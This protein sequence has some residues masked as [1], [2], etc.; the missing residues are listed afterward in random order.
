MS[1]PH[2]MTPLSFCFCAPSLFLTGQVLLVV[3]QADHIAGW[4]QNPV[5]LTSE[6]WVPTKLW[7]HLSDRPPKP[8]QA[9]TS[10][11]GAG[12]FDYLGSS[13]P[14]QMFSPP[15]ELTESFLSF[16]DTDTSAQPHPESDQFT[17]PHQHLTNKMTPPRKLPENILKLKGDQNHSPQFKRISD[18][19]QATDNQLYE[20]LAPSLDSENSR[21]TKFI[22]SPQ[23]LKKDLAQHKKFAKVIVGT[24]ANRFAKPP[25]RKET[26]EDDYWY[27]SMNEAYSDSLSLQSQGNRKEPP[28]PS[29]QVEP[30]EYQLE[31]QSQD[32]ENL[33]A[34]QKGWNHLSPR[35]EEND[36][37]VQKEEPVHQ[38]TSEEAAA[39]EQPEINDPPPDRIQSQ[40]SN[41]PNVTVK[42]LDLEVTV[43]SGADKETQHT[44]SQKQAPGHLSES[45]EDMGPPLIQQEASVQLLEGPGEVAPSLIQQEAAAPNSEFSQE[46]EPPL[47]QQESLAPTPE[48]SEGL[49]PSSTQQEAPAEIL[50]LPED[51][52]NSGI[53]LEVPALP[54]KLPEEISPLV[55]QE[56]TVPVSESSTQSIA[57]TP[58]ATIPYPT[59]YQVHHDT[60]PMITVKPPDVALTITSEPFKEVE[61]SPTQEQTPTQ[62]SGLLVQA[63]H[64]PSLEQHPD[65]LSESP[66]EI[67]SSESGLES[68]IQF[69]EEAEEEE[70][71]ASLMQQDVPSQHPGP[72]LEDESAPIELEQPAQPS[73]SLEEVGSGSGSHPEV[74]VIPVELPEE[75]MPPTEQVPP[76]QASES[77]VENVVETPPIHQVTLQPTQSEEH[78]YHL[79][80]VAVRPVDVALTITSE[81]TK[82]MESS[83][84]QHESPV[85][86]LEYTEGAEPFLSEQEQPAQPSE[87][88]IPTQSSEHALTQQEQPTLPSEYHEVTVSPSIHHQTHHSN[89]SSISVQPPDMQLTI[90]QEPTTEMGPPPMHQEATVKPI[91]V[92]EKDVGTSTTQYTNPAVTPEPSEGIKPL[93][94]QQESPVQTLEPV[95][96]ENPSLN[97]QE[98]TDQNPEL[99][100]ELEPSS[101]QQETPVQTQELPHETVVQPPAHH[102][103]TGPDL[104]PSQVHLPAPHGITAKPP[105]LI[106]EVGTSSQQGFEPSKDQQEVITQP[107]TLLEN[108]QHSSVHPDVPSQPEELPG[109][110][111]SGQQ[112][113]ISSPIKH[114]LGT[115][116]SPYQQEH[117]DKPLEPPK[118]FFLPPLGDTLYF[119]PEDLEA[120]FKYEHSILHKTTVKH[121]N[122]AR[123]RA[124]ESSMKV[125]SLQEQEED[126][127]QPIGS[128]EQVEFL[129]VQTESPESE[130]SQQGAIAQK[131][132]LHKGVYPF[133]TQQEGPYL[134][135]DS[136]MGAEPS[137]AQLMTRS[138]PADLSED[139]ELFPA[140]QPTHPQ[141]SEHPKET[142]LS[143]T[144]QVVPHQLPES[145]NN[146]V[147]YPPTYQMTVSTP[148]QIQVEYSASPIITFQ[149]LDLELTI[150]SQYTPEADHA[151][152][153]KKTTPP[154]AHPLVTFPHQTQQPLDMELTVTHQSTAEELPQTLPETATQISQPPRVIIV[155]VPIYHVVTPPT[156]RQ[157]HTEY[158]TAP[159]FSFQPLD[160]ELTINSEPTRE[161]QPPTTTKTTVPPPK[162]PHVQPLD[163]DLTITH[164]PTAQEELPQ[165]IPESTTHLTESTTEAVTSA[166][167]YQEVTLPT[168]HQDHTEY[169]T[170]PV[171]SFQ[172]LDLEL[173]ISSEPTRETQPPTTTKMSTVPPPKPPTVQP[174]DLELTITSQFTTE[175]E[176]SQI[177][178]EITTQISEPPKKV[179]APVPIYQQMAIPTPSQDQDEY[180]IMPVVS[181]QPVDLELT[182][183]P[184]HTSEGE[185]PQAMPETTTHLTEPPREAVVPAPM[186]QEVT[187]PT[188]HHGQPEYPT[189]PAVSFQPLDLELTISSEP[190]R[191]TQPPTT[192]KMSTVPPPKPPTVQPLDLELTITPQPTPE[193]ELPQTLPET[194]T[195][196]SQPPRVIIVPVPIYQEVTLLTPRQ[197]HTEYPTAPVFSFQPLDLELTI[198]H[199]P[200]A[201]VE[202]PQIMQEAITQPSD[203]PKEIRAQAPEFQEVTFPTPSQVHTQHPHP[204]E[205]TV[206][207]LDQEPIIT[208]KSTSEVEL[209]QTTQETTTQPPDTTTNVVP[210]AP[211]SPEPT[212]HLTTPVVSSQPLDLESTV[213]S[214]PT[215]VTEYF[216]A[217]QETTVSPPQFHK[218]AL[219]EQDTS[220][221][222]VTVTPTS[223]LDVEPSSS[224][225]EI[226]PEPEQ[227]HEEVAAQAPVFYEIPAIQDHT[228]QPTLSKA[229]DQHTEVD[230]TLPV[231][232]T[233]ETGGFVAPYNITAFPPKHQEITLV[234]ED[235]VQDQHVNP[236]QATS[237]PEFSITP[238]PATVVKRSAPVQPT[239]SPK[240]TVTQSSVHF[241]VTTLVHDQS[242]Q[243]SSEATQK[244]TRSTVPT[245]TS[246]PPTH[247]EVTLS[248][249]NQVQ[250]QQPNPT[251][252]TTLS[253]H[254]ESSTTPQPVTVVSHS[255][256]VTEI[257]SQHPNSETI[258]REV[259]TVT[260]P[261]SYPK[262][263]LPSPEQFQT[264]QIP[265]E[266]TLQ[267]MDV[268]YTVTPYAAH[269]N[270]EKRL[271]IKMKQNASMITNLCDF[272]LCENGTLLCI[273]LSPM[274]RLHQVPVP[275][276]STYKG[277]LT[278]LNFQGN[279]ISY[280]DKN[281]WRAYRWTEKLILSENLL[282]ELHKDSFEGLL[283]LQVLDL[284]CNKIRY[285]ERRTFESLPFL[286]YMN[287][288]CNL[289]T[290]LSYGTFQAWH[291]MQF[292][293]KL[294]LSQNPLTIVEDPYLYKLPA[295]KYLDLGKT[296][297][298]LT[299]LENILMMT[300]ELEHL[301]LP[302]HMTCC[303]CK[304]KS[305]IEVVCKTVKLH[306]HA[307]CLTNTTHCFEAP[308]GNPEGS[309]MKVLQAR[310]ENTSTEL[311]IE[312][313]R[314]YSDKDDL[315]SSGFM[316]EQLDFNDESDVI[317]ALNYILPYFS[318]GNLEDVVSTLLPFIKLLFSN[319]QNTDS[320]LESY[321]NDSR[322]LALNPVP[323]AS[324][325][326][327]K[328]KLNKLYFLENLLDAEIDEVR[329]KEKT[330]MLM[331]QSGHLSPKFKRRIFGK[332]WAPARAEENGLAEIEKAE[333]RLH[334]LNRVLKGT[335]SAQKRPIREVSDKRLGNKQSVQTPVES[336]TKDGQLG[337]P[338]TAELQQLSLVQKPRKLA[339]NSFH[340]EPFPPKE[341]GESVSS[342]PEQSLVDKT[343]STKSLPEFIDRR[344]DL[345]YTIFILESANANVKRTK[346]SNPSLLSKKRYR[347]LRKKKSHF[348]LIAKSPESSAVRNLVNSPAEGVLSSL[349]DLSYEKKP[350][351]ELYAASEPPTE[352]LLEENQAATDDTEENSLKTALTGPEEP[353]SENIPIK[354]PAVESNEPTADLITTAQQ[355]SELQLSLT[356]VSDSDNHFKEF[357][358]PLLMSPGER[359][360]SQLNQQL[361]PLIPN[362]NVRRLIAHVIRTL[363]MDCSDPRVQ[364]SCAKLISRT[365]LLMKLLSE[366]Q[367]FKLS[368]ADWDTDQWK[369]ENYIN[370]STETQGEQKGLEPSQ[371]TKEVPGYGYNNKVILAI[372]V[373]VVVTVLIIIFCLIEVYSHRAARDGDEEKYT[374]SKRCY[375]DCES[376]EG[377]FWL[378]W[379]LWLRDMYRP[380]HDTRKKNM[381]QD[382]QDKESSGEE[383]IFKKE[384]GQ[385]RRDAAGPETVGH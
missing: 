150:T 353:A 62:T 221:A 203:S 13:A 300:L 97:Q 239:E 223:H 318:E 145:V 4:V 140:L 228:Q 254:T 382:L 104:V 124:P 185:L 154:P 114:T 64:Y 217:A 144:Q 238:R 153:P 354:N 71:E 312:P 85:H 315:S 231:I 241:E 33:G 5:R 116:F 344:K 224:T 240:G 333:K 319:V 48:L 36:S 199:Q 234:P 58:A 313:E 334:S 34:A 2:V 40:H 266:V 29:G 208:S 112:G 244:T 277:T 212:E 100:E 79:P 22:A 42:P 371:R 193:G 118:D 24:T 187:L 75:A 164:Q 251:Q 237:H 94:N 380:L 80:H 37:S 364:L 99:P 303:L 295:L 82:E 290:E 131:A 166:P 376:Q 143:A 339:G 336:I 351:S 108:Q 337:S 95:Q 44:L 335:G 101:A 278:V 384:G 367:E 14:S 331:Q 148:G 111:S 65:E 59:Q 205:V 155:P 61:M 126:L 245:T 324:K 210:T 103:A 19:D 275:R 307:G 57:E 43:I 274:R 102:E 378:R 211:P 316:D 183:T 216:T 177:V 191:E 195:Q 250:T 282:T 10:Q 279:A 259:P 3:I 45:A 249:P 235:Q 192:T 162:P 93:S 286:K 125:Y 225:Q 151:T 135:P 267:P 69:P 110:V 213:N 206:Q 230:H 163:L 18:L 285:I 218:M 248:P 171:V 359:F 38:F 284:S 179:V 243:P 329:K 320:S 87:L 358:Y 120:I 361:R 81:P 268:E 72:L 202:L 11:A 152:V 25:S 263:I 308:I 226:L 325:M 83:L 296:H 30:P 379:P 260:V 201:Q 66:A 127:L 88:E 219:L 304:F 372:S 167:V 301:I 190:T 17:V 310:R 156:P 247:H 292:L 261:P 222:V 117:P 180:P 1:L 204:T 89:L 383:E 159:V 317:S 128:T 322:S 184:Q 273:H 314:A 165:T 122:Q 172:P 55:E 342:S 146:I 365:G 373:T 227:P 345:S 349:G 288:G 141:V 41:M 370:E 105:V 262:M 98:G 385:E 362:N 63:A 73:E 70:E 115:E 189:M 26:M 168:P 375:K 176:C 35:R 323:K 12:N 360:E 229:T 52:E 276:P 209:T 196:I 298:P 27:P 46:L 377:F 355:T 252:V 346:G 138:Q 32:S 6:P 280:I 291:G 157:D 7:W 330:A 9:H 255:P 281:V 246:P 357:A 306:C 326:A 173:T 47:S 39:I 366:Q 78:H 236:T 56:G 132:D 338:P 253:S 121:P 67:E 54:T 96:Y 309:F 158:P 294:I 15:L 31:A 136:T 269:F 28:E 74:L 302:S 178:S 107:P 293:Q 327:Y 311:T 137:P 332:R 21:V 8:P 175:G 91:T 257:T 256:P 160:L 233:A 60:L 113:N 68:Q 242:Q 264:Q 109:E 23:D 232:S 16:Q 174:L 352:K 297:V 350:F 129:Q 283:S 134:P 20:I 272:C 197:D 123:T 106:N 182:I 215:K 328:N 381:A 340:S 92:P 119:S 270:T 369:T 289:L 363:K 51:L 50:E 142:E 207:P 341:H 374:G 77:A 161:T 265:S 347:N 200:T 76:L 321:K 299:A 186:Y 139:V 194:A 305:D 271:I 287:L 181:F 188:P 86:P 133:P 348:Q 198:A 90:T 343:P 49:E 169:P 149:P 53:Q 147:M 368:R 356:L 84:T 220:K 170:A 130:F 258:E 214:E